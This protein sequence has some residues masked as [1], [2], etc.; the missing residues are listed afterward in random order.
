MS[1]AQIRKKQFFL[2]HDHSFPLWSLGSCEYFCL[3]H[4][5]THISY[6]AHACLLCRSLFLVALYFVL[7]CHYFSSPLVTKCGTCIYITSNNETR[8]KQNISIRKIYQVGYQIKSTTQIHTLFPLFPLLIS[9]R[10]AHKHAALPNPSFL[11]HLLSPT[12]SLV[13]SYTTLRWS[14]PFPEYTYTQTHTSL[15]PSP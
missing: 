10:W 4:T 1:K 12:H 8:P 7:V 5:R 3:T 15:I 2:R 13:S 11:S 9:K 6:T 14:F